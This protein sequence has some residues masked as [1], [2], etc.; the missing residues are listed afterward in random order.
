MCK[1]PTAEQ[2]MLSN[3]LNTRELIQYVHAHRTLAQTHRGRAGP[4]AVSPTQIHL[5]YCWWWLVGASIGTL[6]LIARAAALLCLLCARTRA[7]LI[8]LV[9]FGRYV[10]AHKY[11][12][13]KEKNL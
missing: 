12:I 7:C 6:Y 1:L 9:L 3:I 2:V 4:A 13:E 8:Q 5:T 11:R 10:C